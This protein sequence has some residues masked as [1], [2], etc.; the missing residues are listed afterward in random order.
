[1]TSSY[2]QTG[3]THHTINAKLSE[4]TPT[5][6]VPHSHGAHRGGQPKLNWLGPCTIVAWLYAQQL[7]LQGCQL[8]SIC[9]LRP[10]PSVEVAAPQQPLGRT[11]TARLQ[12]LERQAASLAVTALCIATVDPLLPTNT[13]SMLVASPSAQTPANQRARTPVQ[14]SLLYQLMHNCHGSTIM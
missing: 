13:I 10:D 11:V 8:G 12:A 14:P 9:P 7:Y 2:I 5:P 4:C 1:M 6:H 3:C